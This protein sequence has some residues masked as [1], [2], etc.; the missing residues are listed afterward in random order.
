MTYLYL[1]D[2]SLNGMKRKQKIKEMFEQNP[3]G[4][5]AINNKWQVQLK[6]DKDLQKLIKEG[7]LKQ[8]RQHCYSSKRGGW[9]KGGKS[10]SLLVLNIK[11]TV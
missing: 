9:K 4:M 11:E 3:E 7:F 5:V 1:H 2:I 6:Y 8:I 10:Q